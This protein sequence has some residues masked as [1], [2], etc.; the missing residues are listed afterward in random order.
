ML[1]TWPIDWTI[2]TPPRPA[3]TTV[4]TNTQ[5][6]LRAY[7]IAGGSGTF[8][9]VIKLN[10]ALDHDGKD[11]AWLLRSGWVIFSYVDYLS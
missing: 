1:L 7:R 4:L 2:T 11:L 6:V 5:S 9:W 10:Q 3:P 8:V